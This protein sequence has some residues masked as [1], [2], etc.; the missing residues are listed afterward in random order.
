MKS[1]LFFAVLSFSIQAFSAQ[2]IKVKYKHL[3]YTV[4]QDSN[5]FVYEDSKITKEYLVKDCNKK[6]FE[7][8]WSFYNS[9]KKDVSIFNKHFKEESMT[10]I[11]NNKKEEINPNSKLGMYL[12]KVKTLVLSFEINEKKKCIK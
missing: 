6:Q 11:E 8:F 2:E 5:K 3:S 4:K 9:N 7:I 10:L 1:F 12:Q